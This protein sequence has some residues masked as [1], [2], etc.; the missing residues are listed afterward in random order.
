MHTSAARFPFALVFSR[1]SC[2]P[3]AAYAYN[4]LRTRPAVLRHNGGKAGSAS[5]F[6]RFLHSKTYRFV[7]KNRA[8]FC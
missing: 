3:F 1:R 6:T 8:F 2:H 7:C 4:R 5:V